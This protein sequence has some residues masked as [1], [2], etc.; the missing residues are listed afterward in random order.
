MQRLCWVTLLSGTVGPYAFGELLTFVSSLFGTNEKIG[1][2]Y[3]VAVGEQSMSTT[4]CHCCSSFS[5]GQADVPFIDAL[6]RLW[7]VII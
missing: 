6:S 7:V 5:L 3:S 4:Q 1:T 2:L